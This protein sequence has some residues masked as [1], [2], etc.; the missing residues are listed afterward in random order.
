VQLFAL[1]PFFASLF[2]FSSKKMDTTLEKLESIF[3]L[4]L[5][6]QLQKFTMLGVK[7]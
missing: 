5:R 1:S 6:M 2:Y 7:E 4:C 3:P